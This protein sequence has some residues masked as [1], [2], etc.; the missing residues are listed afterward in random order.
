MIVPSVA[1]VAASAGERDRTGGSAE[2][3]HPKIGEERIPMH[4]PRDLVKM[5]LV[6][7][8]ACAVPAAV[9]QT[10]PDTES[11]AESATEPSVEP[12]SGE[13]TA[14]APSDSI[15]PF[16]SFAQDA[17]L[18]NR[19]WW[20]PQIEYADRGDVS[21][22]ALRAVIA[23]RPWNRVELGFRFGFANSDTPGGADDG[24]G[25]TDLDF[26]GKYKLGADGGR[27]E[28]AVGGLLTIPTGDDAEGL[29][30]DSFGVEGFG[31]M[32]YRLKRSALSFQAG[33]RYNA[34][35]QYVGVDLD[36]K[37]SV[38]LGVAW[39]K[40]LSDAT[41]LVAEGRFESERFDGFDPDARVLAGIDWRAW[42]KGRVRI[43]AA[44]GLADGAPDFQASVGCAFTF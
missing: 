42:S 30:T 40:P 37:S 3:D 38:M 10:E 36:G 25:A 31:S 26:W 5:T 12:T 32:R 11:P 16:L 1:A 17:S 8:L 20:E 18:A 13:T 22:T 29:G 4:V 14:A 24:S 43:S 35:G 7:A 19:Q 23:L 27:T 15:R 41:A 44:A 2:D 9:A 21:W 34:S 39:L 6:L 33:L 28:F